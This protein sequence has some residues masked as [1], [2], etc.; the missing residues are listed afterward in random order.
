[1][2]FCGMLTATSW[3]AG[4]PRIARMGRTPRLN[5]TDVLVQHDV[6]VMNNRTLR[7][8]LNVQNVFNQQTA[9]H[10]FNSYNRGAGVARASSAVSLKSVDL[11]QG[12]DYKALVAATPDAQLPVGAVDPRYGMDD[13]FNPPLQGYV[14]VKFIF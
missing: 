11:S 13:L 14:T 9:R 7:F 4:S 12:Y 1:M 3:W 10:I 6:K 8:E 2:N 5:Q